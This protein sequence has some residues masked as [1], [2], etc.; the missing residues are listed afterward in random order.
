MSL[1]L[2]RMLSCAFL[3][4]L[5]SACGPEVGSEPSSPLAS[6]P[7]EVVTAIVSGPGAPHEDVKADGPRI[8]TRLVLAKNAI[9]PKPDSQDLGPSRYGLILIDRSGSMLTVRDST[10]NTRCYDS[11][12]QAKVELGNLFDP[13]GADRTH[14]AVWSFTDTEVTKHTTAPVG[15]AEAEAA[16][17]LVAGVPCSGNTPLA[18]SMCFAIDY[19]SSL[20]PGFTTYLYIGTDGYENSSDGPCAGPSGT[21]ADAASWHGK[22][23]KKANDSLVKTS[24]SFWVSSTDLEL[25]AD[26]QQLAAV[27]CSATTPLPCDD[28]LFNKLATSSGGEYRRA[29]DT[30][31]SFPCA[32]SASCPVPLSVP[33]GNVLP[34]SVSNTANATVNTANQGIHLRVGETLTVGTCGVTGAS[35]VGDTSIKL[36]APTGTLLA[37]NDDSCGLLSKLT[38]TATTTGVYQVRVGCFANNPCN[39]QLAYTI[40]G[41][42]AFT[43]ANTNNGTVNTFN[44]K[45]YLR[46]GQRVQM[47]TCGVAGSSGLGDT[48]LR[49]FGPGAQPT[50]LVVNDDACGGSL[51]NFSYAVPTTI[52]G[53]SEVRVGCFATTSC[54]GTVAY[55]LIDDLTG[56][57]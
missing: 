8:P 31:T 40:A 19:L 55:Q 20:D 51:S 3:L 57:P 27:A 52:A 28:Q 37:Q 56:G 9:S 54:S 26:S 39:G 17:D 30:N 14:V 23:F 12:K 42:F 41:S 22:V 47:G 6:K 11:I 46:P 34:F 43:A 13:N 5:L 10:K 50:Q 32:N 53:E 15:K 48:I 16:I 1:L 38:Y 25:R 7:A 49:L 21:T 44:S 2:K 35:G 45:V 29:V 33:R 18:E 24:T 4:P 36:Y